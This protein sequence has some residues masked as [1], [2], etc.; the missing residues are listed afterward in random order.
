MAKKRLILGIDLGTTFSLACMRMGEEQFH[1]F[2]PE[3]GGDPLVP[4]VFLNNPYKNNGQSGYEILV[5]AKAEIEGQREEHQPHTVRHVKRSMK[6]NYQEGDQKPETFRSHG[7]DF[8]PY[9]ISGHILKTLKKAAEKEFV[10]ETGR[11]PRDEY[12]WRGDIYS[13]VITVPAYFG[14]SERAAT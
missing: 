14:P 2:T 3:P 8:L 1:F 6:R 12:E 11:I 9:Q 5:G 10:S 7:Q 4:S 13:A